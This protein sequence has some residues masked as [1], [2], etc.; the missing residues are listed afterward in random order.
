MMNTTDAYLTTVDPFEGE[1][2]LAYPILTFI[3]GSAIILN[4]AAMIFLLK[5]KESRRHSQ[6]TVFMIILLNEIFVDCLYIFLLFWRDIFEY[7]CFVVSF[8]FLVCRQNI[9]THLIY[10]CIE[11]LCA[12]KL[13]RKEIFS[14]MTK[15]AFLGCSIAL[16]FLLF[17]PAYVIYG[18]GKTCYVEEMFYPDTRAVLN[19]VR[20]VFCIEIFV[21]CFLYLRIAKEIGTSLNTIESSSSQK[22]DAKAISIQTLSSRTVCPWTLNN[23][24][25]FEETIKVNSLNQSV[26]KMSMRKEGRI[27]EDC[28]E[29]LSTGTSNNV[30]DFE[31]TIESDSSN[32]QTQKQSVMRKTAIVKEERVQ[33]DCIQTLSTG[34]ACP[35][36]KFTTDQKTSSNII[37]L[38]ENSSTRMALPTT[39]TKKQLLEKE[40]RKERPHDGTKINPGLQWKLRALRMVRYTFVSTILPSL[41][42][43]VTQIIGYI[44]PDLLNYTVDVVISVCNIVHAVVF[45]LMFIVTVKK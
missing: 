25:D 39:V 37:N 22:Q 28:V 3:M 43:A 18:K 2:S 9:F 33:E 4:I 6:S 35:V 27:Q 12:L 23:S 7:I 41:P 10:I 31:E 14:T 36:N 5:N 42:M 15:I 34:I 13:S 20:R 32:Q 16:S 17:T 45:P 11:R 30:V 21:T 1:N 40:K 19:Y 38:Q 26:M 29:T 44:R 24:V 8:L